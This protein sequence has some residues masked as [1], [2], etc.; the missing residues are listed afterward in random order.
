MK[1]RFRV[2]INAS[3]NLFKRRLKSNEKR[4]SKRR[5]HYR[6]SIR[7]KFELKGN[8]SYVNLLD[9]WLPKNISYLLTCKNSNFSIDK[10]IKNVP[11]NNG[12]FKVPKEFSLEENAN[13]S[14]KFIQNLL[15][16]LILQ[17]YETV[18]I[19][20]INC[21]KID[22]GAQVLLDIILKD[23]ILFY[24]KC[25]RFKRT[26]I[27]VK[28]IRGR[29]VINE[30]VR[31]LLYSVGS[32]AI[33]NNQRKIMDGVI[34]YP[35][36]I[37]NREDA[38]NLIK[39]QEQKDIDTTKLMDYVINSLASLKLTLTG[40]KLD[41]LATVIGEI[42][43]NAEEHSTTKF[44]FSIGYFHKLEKDG[45]QHGVL[46]LAILNFGKTIYEKFKDPECKNR[47]VVNKMSKLSNKYTKNN[48]FKIK[49]FHEETLWT[50]YALQDG[51]TS[52]APDLYRK[53][54][55]G[56]IT[57]IESFFNIKGENKNYDQ[58]S[59]MTILSGNTNITFD[60]TYNPKVRSINGE[61]YKLMTFNDSGKL[62][63]KPDPKYVKFVHNYF[64]GTIIT[65]KILFNED[66]LVY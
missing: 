23:L 2:F 49:E 19:D 33:H 43:I 32:P 28:R 65:A 47:D 48:L 50:L 42:L 26:R 51:V 29:N 59:K 16:A 11:D 34:P 27:R 21:S 18:I 7:V 53:R 61:E 4:K 66:D 6:D 58:F 56:S 13:E 62:E 44:R 15:G 45:K 8:Y 20:Y 35:L 39:I 22:I 17:K 57:F 12:E 25:N 63:D 41:D 1:N 55:T 54:G 60:G 10:A 3:N 52:V 30:N 14:Y 9:T 31:Q 24:N 36:C 46:K 64:P 5:L 37:H 38:G 40:D